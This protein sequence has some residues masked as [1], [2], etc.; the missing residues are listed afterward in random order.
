M[1]LKTI[2]YELIEEEISN[3]EQGGEKVRLRI[4][5]IKRIAY[6]IIFGIL[7][8]GFLVLNAWTWA[9]I[10]LLIYFILLYNTNNVRE[11]TKIA[12]KFPDTNIS[13]LIRME[14]KK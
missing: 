9:F 7:F 4:L 12:K 5:Y 10:D 1:N 13:H 3:I 2:M 14:M 8:A 11:I 6:T